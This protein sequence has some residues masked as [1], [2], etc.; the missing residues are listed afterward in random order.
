MQYRCLERSKV[1][2][3]VHFK[4]WSAGLDDDLY[5]LLAAGRLLNFLYLLPLSC[6]MTGLIFC[7]TFIEV[8]IMN[9]I[10]SIYLK[11]IRQ[12]QRMLETI[13]QYGYS[14]PRSVNESQEL[15]KYVYELQRRKIC[16]Q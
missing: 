9:D 10:L 11:Y 12:R 14:H 15:D 6:S 5:R 7:K 16:V 1:L 13:S 3:S 4:R 8:L 2:V